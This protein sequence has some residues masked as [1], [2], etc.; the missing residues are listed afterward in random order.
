MGAEQLLGQGDMSYGQCKACSIHGP[1]VSDE[2]VESRQLFEKQAC[3]NILNK[4]E[5]PEEAPD[6]EACA[7]AC[8]TKRW[9][10]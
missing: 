7:T 9:P 2:E 4:M 5:E 8:M 1:F 10:L 6:M 3:P